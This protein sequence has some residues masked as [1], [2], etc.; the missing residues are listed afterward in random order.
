[1]HIAHRMHA[2]ANENALN[3]IGGARNF[4]SAARV[5]KLIA[6]L[7]RRKTAATLLHRASMSLRLGSNGIAQD[8]D[9][10]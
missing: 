3:T 6:V 10:S 5:V 1:M 8:H 9:F 7:W 2:A 4:E